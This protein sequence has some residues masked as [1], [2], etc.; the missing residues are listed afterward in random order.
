MQRT[1]R[2]RLTWGLMAGMLGVSTVSAQEGVIDPAPVSLDRPIDFERD[3]F[4]ILDANCIACHNVAIKENNLILEDVDSILKGGKRG[5][6]VVAKDPEKSLLYQV[7]RRMA[8]AMPPLPNKVEANALTPEELGL[9]RQWILEGAT[10]GSGG[11]MD[12]IKWQAIPATAKAIYAV[13]MTPDGQFVACGRANKITIYS[14]A[15]GQIVAQLADPNLQAVQVDGK[16]LYDALAAHRDFVHA[17]AFAPDGMTLASGDYRAAK[18]WKRTPDAKR[19]ELTAG[20]VVPTVAVSP[21]NQWLAIGTAANGIKLVQ[22]ADGQPVRELAGHTGPVTS[23][24]FSADSTKLISSSA[25]QSIR[26]WNPADGALLARIDATAPV[27]SVAIHPAG[28]QIV[29]GQADNLVH[30]HSLPAAAPKTVLTAAAAVTHLEVSPDRK[31]LAIPG[32]EGKIDIIDL[33]TGQV[34]KSLT[35]HT[36]AINSVSFSGN[37]TR[38]ISSGADKTSRVWDLATGQALAVLQGAG[39]ITTAAALSPD[40]NQ[41]VSGTSDAFLN[42]WNLNVP[43]AQVLGGD[44]GQAATVLTVSPDG[45]RIATAAIADGK[46]VVQI[47][48]IAGGI[49]QTLTGH[50]GAITALAFSPDNQR[51]ISGSADLTSRIWTIGDSKEVA[52]FTAPAAVTAVA[53]A[54]GGQQGVVGAADNSLKLWNAADGAELKSFA[55][56]T[57]AVTAVLVHPNGQILSASADQSIRVWNPA[58]GA[59]LRA[60]GHGQ[61]VTALALTRD[62]QK[63]AATGTDATAKL[64]Q[65]DNGNPLFTL[66]GHAAP[67]KTIAAS[68]D[69]TRLISTGAD[70]QAIVW[71]VAT[72]TVLERF[73]VAAGI[74]QADFVDNVPNKIVIAQ[75]DKTLVVQGTHIERRLEGNQKAITDVLFHRNGGV[76]FT[77]SEDGTIRRYQT[78]N[79]QQEFAANH[80][81]PVWD[82]AVSPD[83]QWLASAGENNVI[84]V[85]N[86][87]NGGD[88]PKPSFAGFEAPVRS[89]TF[90]GQAG[91]GLLVV[92]GSANNKVLAFNVQNGLAAQAFLE[93]AGAVETLATTGEKGEFI[94]SAGA[95]K[96]VRQWTMTAVQQI[97][98]HSQPVT[99]VAY[100]LPPNDQVLSGAGDNTVRQWSIG[101]AQQVR[102][103]DLGG[104][105]TSIALRADGQQLAAAGANNLTRLW[106]FGNAQVVADLRG[107]IRAQRLVA[108]LTADDAEFKGLVGTTAANIK[109]AETELATRTEA[110]KKALEAK[111]KAAE[112]VPPIEAKVKDATDKAAAAQKALDDKKDDAALQKAKTDADKVLTDAQAELK[113]VQDAKTTADKG[114]DQADKAV[115][116]QTD[117]LAVANQKSAAAIAGQKAA[118][119]AVKVGQAAATATEKPWRSVAFSPDGKILAATG[120]DQLI[121]T[122]STTDGSA[123]DVYTGHTGAVSTLAFSGDG[124]LVSGGADQG[125]KAWTVTPQWSLAGQLGPKADAPL[126]L[127]P[128]PFINRVLALDFSEDG[129][130]LATGGGDPS[131]SG[132]V[133]IWDVAKLELL[134]NITDAHSDTV[135]GLDFSRDGQF[136]LSGAADKFV[137]IFDVNSGKL[138]KS[139]E[140]HT[141]HVMD[142]S[143]KA[144]QTLI[145]SAGADNAIK[146]WSVET[147][148]QQRTIAGYS[149]QVTS[150]AFVGRGNNV[151]SCGGDATV[152]FHQADNG[153][154]FRNFGG[155]TDYM[156]SVAASA[157]EKLVAAGGEDGILRVWNGTNAQLVI[158]FE[159]PALPGATQQAAAK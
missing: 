122:Y 61:A 30:V 139:F 1:W 105:V 116:E 127:K 24:T 120:D 84:R 71:D 74:A 73:A 158:S 113:T 119:E 142:V 76:V 90:A 21:N 7:S 15:T 126:D 53:F 94:V 154:N 101:N 80:G 149:K 108:K 83:G 140:G 5:P 87:G 75:A 93:H 85:W 82:L 58:D 38:L 52:K 23:V 155:A 32:A 40:G 130:L 106:N 92:G 70:N 89:V 123:L 125:V 31:W 37:S 91:A 60:I 117:A 95:D 129:K 11:N 81:A 132:E 9:L 33:S 78:G 14:V 54:A 79:G 39:E 124:V 3:I 110:A 96:T 67:M 59:Q 35:G 45:K 157:D 56:H 36:G 41:A 86:E 44:N 118:E 17:L 138:V 68:A 146:I 104:P 51:V 103:F 145:A 65:F 49:T 48:D 159:P 98:G 62:G 152:R 134:K 107:D 88:A 8:P 26:V 141:H 115:K 128:S 69:N 151:I 66:T 47:R 57:G 144:D 29:V 135:F 12:D 43:A 143:W 112:A 50:E 114:A 28:T 136:L 18:I 22:L 147:G 10:V 4:P 2:S 153:G 148:E 111:T 97:P 109:A 156:Y 77:T 100:V 63:L 133:M 13:A 64:Y 46:P 55:G 16:P 25:D 27:N 150:L 6:S 42:V 19:F 102:A 131:R 20:A 99:S 34:A 137:K 121:H 72:G